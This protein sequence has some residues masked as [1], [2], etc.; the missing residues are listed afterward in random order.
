MTAFG[1]EVEI[2]LREAQR[3]VEVKLLERGVD[4]IEGQRP[5][6]VD[7]HAREECADLGGEVLLLRH[8]ARVRVQ[9]L[10][11]GV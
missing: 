3:R 2:I 1:D 11:F 9:G 8:N 7:I 4:L 5:I 10:G 6:L